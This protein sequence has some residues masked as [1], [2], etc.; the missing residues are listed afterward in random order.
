MKS[1]IDWQKRSTVIFAAFILV[2][3][4]ILAF[5]AIREAE[6]EKLTRENEIREEQEIYAI[7]LRDEIE[8][9]FSDIEV[10]ISSDFQESRIRLDTNGL[11]ESCRIIA[12][13]EK[14]I[15]EIFLSDKEGDVIFA[16]ENQDFSLSE[17]R[18]RAEG[19]IKS[20]EKRSLFKAAESA[21]QITKNFPRAIESYRRLGNTIS[22]KASQALIMNR[23]AR[24]YLKAERLKE[25]LDTYETIKN[26]Y[27]D[28]TSSAGLPLGIIAYNQ[29]GLIYQETGDKLKSAGNLIE[30]YSFLL[31][32]EWFLDLPQFHFYRKKITDMFVSYSTDKSNA[33]NEGDFWIKWENLE[34]LA[35]IKLDQLKSKENLKK[36]VIPLIHARL[37]ASDNSNYKFS[38]FAETV[39][40]DTILVCATTYQNDSVFGLQLNTS[41]LIDERIP[42]ILNRLPIRQNWSAQI[43]DYSGRIL[44]DAGVTNQ[45]ITNNQA[46]ISLSFAQNFPPWKV[47]VFPLNPDAITQHYNRRR[48]FYV[49]AVAIV[50]AVLFFGGFLAIRS[51][52]REIELAKL[53][54]EFVATVSHEFRTPLM[55][56]R[57]LSELLQ[58][59]RVKSKDKKIQYYGKINRESERL[60][61][62]V[63]NILDF[64]TIEAGMKKYRFEDVAISN[65]V[66]DVADQCKEYI[67]KKTVTLDVETSDHLPTIYADK[68]AISRALFN[69]LDN[70]LKYSGQGKK[71]HLCAFTEGDSLLLKV[72]DEGIGIKKDDLKRVFEKFY[73]SPDQGKSYIEGSGIG[74]TLVAHIVQA[75]GGEVIME[76][77]VGKGTTVT[78]QLPMNLKEKMDG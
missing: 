24:C 39:E 23:L 56:I 53:K 72:Q 58:R 16:L 51:T 41:I 33:Q 7:L 14:L 68:D 61:R 50:M 30:F 45:K 26:E 65:L 18:R 15:K 73:R 10:G 57:Y 46:I 40:N 32:S 59:D 69:L 64:S 4:F 20:L 34:K 71:I 63:E 13:R 29:I 12:S 5:L 74:L 8:S 6:R 54:S 37:T 77:E 66:K 55:S 25:A 17:R 31:E 49:L 1:R 35:E 75:H 28:E 11:I 9:L 3:G 19:A 76:S 60:S 38:R 78:L 47:Q 43:I 27:S 44:S 52:A 2:L 42:S 36:R 21:E 67:L 70:S 22:D 48:N 62:L